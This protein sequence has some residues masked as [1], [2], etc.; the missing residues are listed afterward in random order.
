M[1]I[2]WKLYFTRNFFYFN[3]FQLEFLDIEIFW[4]EKTVSETWFD[5][6]FLS[7]SFDQLIWL[8]REYSVS[9]A[10]PV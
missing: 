4:K 7:Q 9:N 8:I 3:N 6:S 5:E 2:N 1:H 10:W